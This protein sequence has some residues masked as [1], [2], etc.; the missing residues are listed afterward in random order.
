MDYSTY[1]KEELRQLCR[2]RGIVYGRLNKDGMIAA[3]EAYDQSP[4]LDEASDLDDEIDADEAVADEEE[5][6]DGESDED[7]EDGE[8]IVVQR[9]AKVDRYVYEPG[10]TIS[11]LIRRL[12]V[13]AGIQPE[14]IVMMDGQTYSQDSVVE[15]PSGAKVTIMSPAGRNA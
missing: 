6:T 14:E 15:I 1:N 9:T 8:E 13:R 11:S 10:L 2:E 4:D 3:L 7:G 5:E 12:R